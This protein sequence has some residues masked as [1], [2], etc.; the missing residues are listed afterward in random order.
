MR[1]L[2]TELSVGLGNVEAKSIVTK[3]LGDEGVEKEKER[4]EQ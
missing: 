3:E 4:V 2:K 1:A